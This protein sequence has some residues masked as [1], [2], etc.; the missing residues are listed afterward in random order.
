VPKL[1]ELVAKSKI[2][3]NS[4]RILNTEDDLI[5]RVFEGAVDLL[6]EVGAYC[7]D[8]NRVMEFA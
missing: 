2:K 6:A 5:D 1:K 4:E 7:P 3:Y 8:T